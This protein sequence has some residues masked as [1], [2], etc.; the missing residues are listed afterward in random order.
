MYLATS[1]MAAGSDNTRMTLNTFIMAMISYPETLQQAQT[2]VDRI[3]GTGS[4][5]R[6]PTMEDMDSLPYLCAMIKEVLRWQPTVPTVPSHQLTESLE[7]DGYRFPAGT[8]FLINNVAISQSFDEANAFKPER[9]VNG[10]EGNVVHD[11]WGFGGGRRI[12]VGYRV[13]QQALFVAFARIVYSFDIVPDG[14]F[15]DRYLN[16]GSLSEPFPVTMSI[17]SWEHR[18]IIVQQAAQAGIPSL[19]QTSQELE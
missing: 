12:C 3:C 8:E 1:V 11:F 2:E 4:T 6:L 13:A 17:R 18:R 14:K 15:D 16:H 19:T 9:W 5:V 7:Y 10:H